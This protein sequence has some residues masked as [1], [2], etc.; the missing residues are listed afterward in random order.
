MNPL[1]WQWQV[2]GERLLVTVRQSDVIEAR[3][4][5][6]QHRI[7][8]ARAE[9]QAAEARL[10]EVNERSYFADER[11]AYWSARCGELD[12]KRAERRARLDARID[13]LG[14]QAFVASMLLVDW[15]VYC[16]LAWVHG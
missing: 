11:V 10:R 14:R 2:A 16:A 4:Q 6:L 13:A 9:E 15:I 5:E 12:M 1:Y 8:E 7:D 3:K